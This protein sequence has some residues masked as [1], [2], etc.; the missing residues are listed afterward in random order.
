[1]NFLNSRLDLDFMSQYNTVYR[2]VNINE[3][4]Y[5]NVAISS[6]LYT[7]SSLS[8]QLPWPNSP[9]Y[10][11]INIQ[12]LNSKY[13]ELSLQIADL[14]SKNVNIDVISLQETW[15]IRY[16]DQLCI[17]GFQPLVYRNRHDMRGG[18]V[19]FYIKNGINYKIL[20]TLSPFEN[21]IFESLTIQLSYPGKSSV[22]LT[23]AY[24]SNGL[25]PNVT[26]S[27]QM[28][29]F[30]LLFDELL[31]NLQ[32]K[33][34]PTYIFMDS[35]IDLLNLNS[36]DS[37]NF[38][39]SVLS[40]GF[41]Q[42]VLKPTRM[43]NN[44]KTLIDHILTS[45]RSNV[46]STGTIV[47][48][49]SDHFFTFI[50]TPN[51]VTKNKEKTKTYRLFDDLNLSRFKTLLGGTNWQAVTVSNSVDIAY[52]EFWSVYSSLFDLTFPLKKTRFNK[53]IHKKAAFMTDGLLKSRETKNCLHLATLADNS[54]E[55]KLRYKNY[56]NLYFKTI[57]AAKKLYFNQK[58][59]ENSKN[60]KKTWDLL[61]EI[62]G[63]S[64]QSVNI[65][66]ITVNDTVTSEPFEIASEFN[67]FFTSAGTRISNSVPP[68]SKQPEDYINYNREIPSLGLGNTTPEHVQKVIKSLAS[69]FSCDIQGINTKIIKFLGSELAL[70]LSHIFNLSLEQGVFPSKLKACRVIPK[71]GSRTECDNYRPISLLSSISKI[72]EKIVAEKLTYH[73]L[74]N[75]LLYNHQYG[76]LPGRSTEQNLIQTLN[77]ITSAL[78]EGLFCVG[79]FLDLRKAFDVCSHEILLKKLKKMGINGTAFRWFS[80]YLSG[81][82][83]CVDV[84]GC[85]SDFIGLDILYL[86]FKEAH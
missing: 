75:D 31:H 68:V 81:R 42:C 5:N 37:S 70:P 1:L 22:L 24:R 3:D 38:L 27:M 61:N 52:D 59:T 50:Q 49:V 53:N 43:Q 18:G 76:F 29:R 19:G 82:S 44:S 36:D 4:P 20:E 84:S 86:L 55:T 64:S 65:D 30:F 2:D 71:T 47:S 14:L 41:L 51:P 28:E 46:L 7:M 58:L 57:R 45:V 74:T 40:K 16:P 80:S 23:S 60:P 73:L 78:N 9:L 25:L 72:L 15:E 66:K 6:K 33:R 26:P 32:N 11:S 63:K 77:F 10:L 69:K 21:K 85:T 48:D 17:P 12:S 83:Q 35:N 54:A 67:R 56:R 34:L 13:N 39:N 79:V 8:N 62:M